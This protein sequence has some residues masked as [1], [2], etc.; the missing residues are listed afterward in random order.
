LTSSD[1]LSVV[2]VLEEL[3]DSQAQIMA[4]LRYFGLILLEPKYLLRTPA[5]LILRNADWHLE[6]SDVISVEAVV[7]ASLITI[8]GICGVLLEKDIELSVEVFL[9]LQI[10]V[11]CVLNVRIVLVKIFGYESP[12]LVNFLGDRDYTSMKL[13][14]IESCKLE[15]AVAF[16]EALRIVPWQVWL[17]RVKALIGTSLVALIVD[18]N[19]MNELS[20]ILKKSL[21]KIS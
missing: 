10:V 15:L 20:K 18:L 14:I 6:K 2:D 21:Q 16:F 8:E 9:F 11:N 17:L 12:K 3:S 13:M 5:E 19:V 7:D 1:S 4:I